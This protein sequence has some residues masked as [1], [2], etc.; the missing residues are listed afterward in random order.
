M[1]VNT[2][3]IMLLRHC[4]TDLHSGWRTKRLLRGLSA[5]TKQAKPSPLPVAPR[6]AA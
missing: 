5:P 4:V 2:S 3:A 6:R 1:T